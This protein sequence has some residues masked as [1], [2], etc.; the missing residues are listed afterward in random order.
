MTAQT[1]E[2]VGASG[3]RPLF[4]DGEEVRMHEFMTR[5]QKQ[6]CK[7]IIPDFYQWPVKIVSTSA[8]RLF[9]LLENIPISADSAT[10]R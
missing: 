4:V 5:F 2:P 3:A 1:E 7:G 6:I 9:L 8:G 10:P